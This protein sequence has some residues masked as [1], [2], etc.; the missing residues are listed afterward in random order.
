M[1]ND[2]GCLEPSG[3][4]GHLICRQPGVTF[5]IVYAEALCEVHDQASPN[6]II[7]VGRERSLETVASCFLEWVRS[8]SSR[9]QLA[10]SPGAPRVARVSSLLQGK[11]DKANRRTSSR[12]LIASCRAAHAVRC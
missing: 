6:F 12:E 4:P 8:G 9:P 7:P 5:K 11:K 2:V 10:L 1:K 3:A